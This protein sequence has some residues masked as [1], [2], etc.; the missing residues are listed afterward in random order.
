MKNRLM[1][2]VKR[3]AVY[4]LMIVAMV[5]L[6]F[7][8]FWM[9]TSAFKTPQEIHSPTPVLF[10][11]QPTFENFRKAFSAAPFGKY[12]MNT[13]LVAAVVTGTTVILCVMA[14]YGFGRLP[15]LGQEAIFVLFTT[16]IGRASCR[17]RV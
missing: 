8:F 16:Q 10:S 15:F 5:Q 13:L 7:P 17:E 12:V 2:L 3:G 11:A 4:L 14:G 9:A 1:K 6:G